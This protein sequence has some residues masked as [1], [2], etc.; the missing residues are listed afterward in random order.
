MPRESDGYFIKETWDTMGMRATRSD[1]TILDGVF[2]PDRYIGRVVPAGAASLDLFVLAIF[3]WSQPMFAS[4]YRAI[5]Q[6]AFD[7]TV[8]TVKKKTSLAL[9]RSMAYHA[10][11]QH[12]IAEMAMELDAIG[13]H[14]DRVAQ[15]WANGVD[16]GAKWAAKLVGMKYMA[17]TGAWRVVDTAMDLM[18]GFGIFRAAGFERLFRDARL[19]RI[20]PANSAS[21]HEFVAKTVLGIDPDETLR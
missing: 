21:A 15:D 2:V 6:R 10:E 1:D 9:S 11:V 16:H 12:H 14:I 3:V 19:G 7:W 20:H 18:G 13:S 17:T 8:D 4:I 5:A